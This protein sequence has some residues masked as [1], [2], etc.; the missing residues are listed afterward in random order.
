M[1]CG[2][3]NVDG[4]HGSIPSRPSGATLPGGLRIEKRKIRGET[5]EGMLCSA[6]ELGLGQ[7]HDGIL[8]LDTDAAPGTP[9]SR[10]AAGRRPAGGRCRRPT[11]PTSWATRASRASWP[12]RYGVPFRLPAFPARPPSM[13]SGSA[14]RQ[15]SASVGGVARRHR[16][17]EG[18]RRL[19]RRRD[20]RGQG[21]ARRPTGW[22]GGSRRSACAPS[23][24]SWTPPTT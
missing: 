9:F 22:P 2:A 4:G 8:E 17:L 1:V 3:P 12:R 5:S 24:T 21:R 13:S 7:D 15:Q 6:R 16:G 11:G 14:R 10:P 18:C 19:H 20:P 23:T